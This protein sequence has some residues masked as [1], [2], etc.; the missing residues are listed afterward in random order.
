MDIRRFTDDHELL[1]K[2][3]GALQ[4]SLDIAR[5]QAGDMTAS[6]RLFALAGILM[7]HIGAE[8][9][10][11]YPLLM[12]SGIAELEEVGKHLQAEVGGLGNDV[13]RYTNRWRDAEAMRTLAGDFVEQT[14]DIIYALGHRVDLED[15][16]LYPLLF[17]TYP[18][19]LPTIT[20]MSQPAPGGGH[21]I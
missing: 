17:R 4:G 7:K 19:G 18:D 13:S 9:R 21:R 2:Q 12:A 20:P 11:V 8:D 1:T 3:A 5:I 10:I 14:H 15:T 16:M 6:T